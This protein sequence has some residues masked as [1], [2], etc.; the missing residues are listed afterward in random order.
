[1]NLK[2]KEVDLK[3]FSITIENM[4]V[5]KDL[6]LCMVVKYFD[7]DKQ[8]Y[9]MFESKIPKTSVLGK[10]VGTVLSEIKRELKK[11]KKHEQESTVSTNIT[12]SK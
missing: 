4:L 7:Q 1:M 8:A 6:K 2:S 9:A 5:G 12:D 11:Q 3:E 10:E